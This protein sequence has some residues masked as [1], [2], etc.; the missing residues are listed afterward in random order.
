METC[1]CD[2]KSLNVPLGS[3]TVGVHVKVSCKRQWKRR[4]FKINNKKKESQSPFYSVFSVD[5]YIKSKYLF[6]TYKHP[7]VS[8]FIVPV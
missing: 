2:R 6:L 1:Y 3:T 4:K 7:F 8:G 5:F